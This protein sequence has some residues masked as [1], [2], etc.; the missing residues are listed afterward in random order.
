MAN[1]GKMDKRNR[2]IVREKHVK[3]HIKKVL[4]YLDENLE[5]VKIKNFKKKNL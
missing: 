3:N 4:L 1:I 5:N 2:R